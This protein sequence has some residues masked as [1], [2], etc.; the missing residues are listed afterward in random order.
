MANAGKRKDIMDKVVMVDGAGISKI[1]PAD[2]TENNKPTIKINFIKEE[3]EVVF[4]C[5]LYAYIAVARIDNP[6][7]RYA[8]TRSILTW[9]IILVD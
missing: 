9:V 4:C 7:G 5:R 6:A 3:D 1:I 8:S 2:I